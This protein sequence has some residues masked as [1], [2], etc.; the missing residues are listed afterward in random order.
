MRRLPYTRKIELTY[1]LVFTVATVSCT[2]TDVLVIPVI[3][4]QQSM[5]DVGTTSGACVSLVMS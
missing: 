2:E 5:E 1:F 3:S 4:N